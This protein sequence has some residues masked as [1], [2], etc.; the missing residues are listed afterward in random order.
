MLTKFIHITTQREG[1]HHWPAAGGPENYLRHPHRHLFV[2]D[3]DLQVTHD[4]REIE[5]N[6]AT[7]WLDTL[8]PTFAVATPQTDTTA[9][10]D[11]GPQSCE[12]LAGRIIEA[13]LQRYGRHRRLR[14]AVLEDGIL[15]AVLTWQPQSP[16]T[17]E[18]STT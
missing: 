13:F 15:G 6:A 4:D 9:P 2:V 12:R 7:R 18:P 5:I 1:L 8:L 10:L 14:C 11:F 3:V 17:P 16:T